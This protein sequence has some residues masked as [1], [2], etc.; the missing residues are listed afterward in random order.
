MRP[1]EIRV[2]LGVVRLPHARSLRHVPH[3]KEQAGDTFEESESQDDDE[4]PQQEA[5][6]TAP[7][8]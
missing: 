5:A 7:H 8:Y 3:E 2:V 6:E 4:E 1:A